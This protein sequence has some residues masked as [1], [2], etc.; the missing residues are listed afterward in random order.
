[1]ASRMHKKVGY[2]KPP[3]NGQF[4]KGQ[5]GNPAG[6]PKGV[7][8]L[9]TDLH[10]VLREKVPVRENG[11]VKNVT[12]Q[13]GMVLS[14]S[15]KAIQGDVR[16]INAMTKLIDQHPEDIEIDIDEE[17]EPLSKIDAEILADFEDE[18][19]KRIL[20]SIK[21][22]KKSSDQPDR[23][24]KPRNRERTWGSKAQSKSTRN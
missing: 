6:R 11:E 7:K 3:K 24:L 17:D 15:H 20:A 16:A 13:H 8:N 2:K 23:P 19:C 1:M 14:L 5:S 21:R 4:K 10:S 12:K 9:K 22:E 18:M